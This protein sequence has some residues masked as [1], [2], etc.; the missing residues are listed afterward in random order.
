MNPDGL[1]M[2]ADALC[3]FA[4]DNQMR[5]D[6]ASRTDEVVHGS[7]TTSITEVPD[8]GAPDTEALVSTGGL[9]AEFDL[10]SSGSTSGG[11]AFRVSHEFA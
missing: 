7:R 6:E 3:Q 5:T 10:P 11:D 1:T 2:L 9:L 4:S 8:D